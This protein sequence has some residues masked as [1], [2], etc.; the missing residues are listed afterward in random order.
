VKD[1]R[2][3]PSGPLKPRLRI[4]AITAG[5]SARSYFLGGRA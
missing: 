1:Q 4:C 2:H 3:Q 5:P